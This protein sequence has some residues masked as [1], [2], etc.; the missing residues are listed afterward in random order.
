MLI[1]FEVSEKG[2]FPDP[3]KVEALRN[4][5]EEEQLADLNSMFHFANYLRE[6]ISNF[7]EITAPLK[8]YRA[9]GAKWE[10]YQ[11]DPKAMKAA[12]DFRNAVATKTPLVNP[13]YQA[14][15]DYLATGRPFELFVDASDYGYS[16]VLTQRGEVHGTP[17]PIAVFGKKL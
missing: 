7:S 5:P 8:P 2:R 11:N 16:A 4:W 6:F 1:G 10:D 17:R 12:K 14:D 9:K 15:R 3:S 13:D